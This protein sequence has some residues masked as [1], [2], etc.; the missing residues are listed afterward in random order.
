MVGRVVSRC[1]ERHSVIHGP[2]RIFYHCFAKGAVALLEV[3]GTTGAV[4][5][6]CPEVDMLTWYVVTPWTVLDIDSKDLITQAAITGRA[7]KI[8]SLTP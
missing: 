3:P 6:S 4:F 8:P 2:E 1:F 7:G 5:E